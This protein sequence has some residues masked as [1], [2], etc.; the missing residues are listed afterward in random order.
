[1]TNL[2][3]HIIECRAGESVGEID[4]NEVIAIKWFSLA[5]IKKMIRNNEIRD[6]CVFTAVFIWMLKSNKI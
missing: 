3:M 6:A 2:V 4:K 1:M 5:E